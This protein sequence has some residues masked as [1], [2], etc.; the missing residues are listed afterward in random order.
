MFSYF[1]D[2]VVTRVQKVF[3]HNFYKLMSEILSR[4]LVSEAK[5]AA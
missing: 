4:F 3:D 5:L 1:T 2:S